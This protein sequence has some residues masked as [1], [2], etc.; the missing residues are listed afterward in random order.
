MMKH[1]VNKKIINKV[2]SIEKRLADFLDKEVYQP[3]IAPDWYWSIKNQ[4]AEAHNA[5][6]EVKH[7]LI[8]K[9]R[10]TDPSFMRIES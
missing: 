10:E 1:K 8:R 3:T 5:L 6:M 9:R 7:A 4:L 2:I